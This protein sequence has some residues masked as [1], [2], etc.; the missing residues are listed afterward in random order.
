M[1]DTNPP[2]D[3]YVTL[4]MWTSDDGVEHA[5]VFESDA[6]AVAY[7]PACFHTRTLEIKRVITDANAR[8]WS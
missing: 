1:L 8:V 7:T 2:K 4:M 5:E 6:V 3:E